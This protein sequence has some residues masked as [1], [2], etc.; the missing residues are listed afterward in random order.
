MAWNANGNCGLVVGATAPDA[1]RSVR[2]LVGDMPI[3]VP[4]VGAQSGDL[5]AVLDAGLTASGTGLLVNASRS[6][7]FAS[8]G[9]DYAAAARR[10]AERLH[11]AIGAKIFKRR[12]A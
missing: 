11:D 3:L 5:E 10:E 7:V 1:L 2:Q 12:S 8:S 6:I 9:P 4:G